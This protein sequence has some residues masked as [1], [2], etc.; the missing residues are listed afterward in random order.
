MKRIYNLL[1][2]AGLLIGGMSI[3]MA[4]KSTKKVVKA[5]PVIKAPSTPALA[6]P[7]NGATGESVNPSLSWNPVDS[8]ITYHLRVATDPSFTSIVSNQDNLSSTNAKVS[9][10]KNSTKY[11]WEVNA[12][13]K[14]GT[15][16]WSS[17][18]SFTTV[19]PSPPPAPPKIELQTIHFDFDKSNI[20]DHAASLLSQNVTQLRDHPNLNVTIDA[21]TDHV[22]GDQYNIRLSIRR[23]DAVQSF[24]TNNGIDASRITAKGLG[25]APVVCTPEQKS[26]TVGKG[27]RYNRRAESHID[28]QPENQ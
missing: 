8:A 4:C 12:S 9:G 25:K 23:A 10:L 21:Y 19:T 18:W 22:G 6:W 16:P 5:A 17:V 14:G 1:F 20:D 15:S 7:E 11:Y 13:N 27:C 24:Y 3:Q 26:E 28:N 2:I